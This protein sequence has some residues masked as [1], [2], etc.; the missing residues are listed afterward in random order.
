M[1]ARVNTRSTTI[2]PG[3][4]VVSVDVSDGAA[5]VPKKYS[6][7]EKSGL[8]TKVRQGENELEFDLKSK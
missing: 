2:Q 8:R 4:Y 3:D 5:K 7:A 6:D 1:F